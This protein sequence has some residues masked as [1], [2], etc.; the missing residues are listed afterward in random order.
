MVH[1]LLFLLLL[2]Y[3]SC[4][5]TLYLPLLVKILLQCNITQL[6]VPLCIYL[7]DA[8]LLL[9]FSQAA[10]VGRYKAYFSD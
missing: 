2:M 4:F 6:M 9:G 5:S 10:L 1:F 3:Y 7:K 8:G